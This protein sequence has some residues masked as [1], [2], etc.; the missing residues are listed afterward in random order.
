[1]MIG[2]LETIFFSQAS[3]LQMTHW[4]SV[5]TGH[6]PVVTMQRKRWLTAAGC[7]LHSGGIRDTPW[8]AITKPRLPVGSAR[9]MSKLL[10]SNTRHDSSSWDRAVAGCRSLCFVW[11]WTPASGE[12]GECGTVS[13]A[14]QTTTRNHT[15][16]DKY[17]WIH[18]I[19]VLPLVT[20]FCQVFG[21][22]T[23]FRRQC[24]A[25]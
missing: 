21:V 23:L 18:R 19:S 25:F 13:R 16:A 20:A 14:E 3:H 9:G 10:V 1:M 12:E 24:H 8:N 7:S 5:N 4:K 11:C 15:W 6:Q 2:F 22:V 17:R